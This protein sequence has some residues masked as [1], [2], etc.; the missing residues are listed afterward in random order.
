VKKTKTSANEK[1]DYVPP[2][3]SVALPTPEAVADTY[4]PRTKAELDAAFGKRKAKAK[5]PEAPEPPLTPPETD[6][7]C[8][9]LKT[10]NFA[11]VKAEK[12]DQGRV[13]YGYSHKDGRAALHLYGAGWTIRTTDGNERGGNTL[14][15]L[16]AALKATRVGNAV[17]RGVKREVE[18]KEEAAKLREAKA[19]AAPDP[20]LVGVLR[21]VEEATA[22]TLVLKDLQGDKK[23]KARLR[24]AGRL[25]ELEA[26]A[27]QANSEMLT[28]LDIVREGTKTF[29]LRQLQGDD[30]YKVRLRIAK[31][32]IGD[33]EA[34]A[35]DA[36]WAEVRKRLLGFLG[37]KDDAAFKVKAAKI[38]N[39][40]IEPGTKDAEWGALR[41]RLLAFI[42]AKDDRAFKAMASDVLQ[43]A[44]EVERVKK[45]EWAEARRKGLRAAREETTVAG[46]VLP[47]FKKKSAAT[48]EEE[49]EALET[50]LK[51]GGRKPKAD[52]PAVEAPAES[53]TEVV[54]PHDAYAKA[55]GYRPGATEGRLAE[56]AQD[57][58]AAPAPPPD[59]E[60]RYLGPAAQVALLEH[61]IT[62]VVM[63]RL[64]LPGLYGGAPCVYNNGRTVALGIV[65]LE[66]L[67]KFR[68]IEKADVQHAARQLLNPIV[69]SVKVEPVAACHLTA[70][71]HCKELTTMAEATKKFESPNAKK[72]A[73][74]K[75]AK[76]AAKKAAKK[77]AAKTNGGGGRESYAG[78]KI[79]VLTKELTARE[80]TKRRKALD[81]MLTTKTTDE[82]IPKLTKI[83][84]NNSFIAFAIREGI[85][86]L[87]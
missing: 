26:G 70:V 77:A 42:G 14:D 46:K 61:T 43:H 75:D 78:K 25:L 87:V 7:V 63:L 23:Y 8:R 71:I 24:L 51:G 66:T 32:L 44:A 20:A 53:D 2:T 50:E 33:D 17:A 31:A 47:P 10:A 45:A 59:G 38:M 86:E 49:R 41:K 6:P 21:Q 68:K 72:T 65:N 83:G 30:K 27:P 29:I 52:R 36:E 35:K 76:P 69:A 1:P 79:K 80:G 9:A 56:L 48:R 82:L 3:T 55:T 67:A 74:V 37:V 15:G 19:A 34:R 81:F 84:A 85:I 11:F 62:G 73:T 4:R 12:D 13:A 64:A 58:A 54:E 60:A 22:A 57:Q 16:R 40:R 28:I 5:A 18:R 39:A